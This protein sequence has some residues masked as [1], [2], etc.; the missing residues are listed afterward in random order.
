MSNLIQNISEY[1]NESGFYNYLAE[2]IES[3]EL[4]NDNDIQE[5]V[6]RLEAFIEQ[7][8]QELRDENFEK[9]NTKLNNYE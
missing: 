4:L 8:I 1:G 6:C 2:Q 7:E 3:E 5:L 9:Y